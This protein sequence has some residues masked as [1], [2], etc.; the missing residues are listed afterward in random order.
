MDC[1]VTFSKIDEYLISELSGER[2]REKTEREDTRKKRKTKKRK[3]RKK[4]KKKRKKNS[5]MR[6]LRQAN[7][8]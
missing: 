3:Q 2:E 7:L 1:C 6:G 4:E 8:S 5:V